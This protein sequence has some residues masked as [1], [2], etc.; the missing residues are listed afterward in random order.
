MLLPPQPQLLALSRHRSA[1][2]SSHTRSPQPGRA[3][4]AVQCCTHVMMCVY[5]HT[6]TRMDRSLRIHLPHLCRFAVFHYNPTFSRR[7]V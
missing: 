2:Q 6:H 5:T 1:A 4:L 3:A 7:R